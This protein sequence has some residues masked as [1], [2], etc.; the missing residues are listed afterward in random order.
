M[1]YFPLQ[2]GQR[3]F[4]FGLDLIVITLIMKTT[5]FHEAIVE[6]SAPVWDKNIISNLLDAAP[7]GACN[8]K[9]E[10]ASQIFQLKM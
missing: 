7:E 4:L 1:K 3:K 9:G 2:L 8:A 5:N 10:A 6:V